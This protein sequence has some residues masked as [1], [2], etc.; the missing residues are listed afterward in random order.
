MRARRT[1]TLAAIWLVTL[2]VVRAISVQD[3]LPTKGCADLNWPALPPNDAAY[4]A[5]AELA[6]TLTERGFIITCVAPSKMTGTFEGQQ[7]AA[8]YGTDRG[9]FDA[10]FLPELQTFDAMQVVEQQENGRY[11]YSFRGRPQ[12]WSANRIDGS[13]P[14][15]FIKHVNQLIVAYDKELATHL[16]TTLAGL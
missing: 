5:A 6:R 3:A 15:Y 10:L 13:R 1:I 7:R 16:R 9:G 14:V 2:A 11:L 12:P 8:L 4:A